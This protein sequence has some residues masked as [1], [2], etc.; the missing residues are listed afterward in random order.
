MPWAGDSGFFDQPEEAFLLPGFHDRNGGLLKEAGLRG[1]VRRYQQKFT[2]QSSQATPDLWA[3]LVGKTGENQ[4]PDSQKMPGEL[5]VSLFCYQNPWIPRLLDYW[6]SRSAPTSLF[7]THGLATNQVAK[8][9][10]YSLK[11]G[12]RRQIGALELLIL[13]FLPPPAYDELLWSCDFNF[14]RG[15]TLLFVLNGRI[16]L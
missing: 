3:R 2:S 10:G 1:Q 13:P 14:V 15:K 8:W 6:S 9:C 7:V 4:L 11:A 12:D 5:R 16:D